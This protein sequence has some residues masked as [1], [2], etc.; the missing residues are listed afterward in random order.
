MYAIRSYYGIGTNG[1]IE[2]SR[3]RETAPERRTGRT[4]RVWGCEMDF[5]NP[6]KTALEGIKRYEKFVTSIGM[7][8]P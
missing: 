2:R 8:I 4:A 5:Q 1:E 6:E 3:E 7:P